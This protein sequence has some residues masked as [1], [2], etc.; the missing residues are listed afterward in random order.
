M[1]RGSFSYPGIINIST[2]LWNYGY[3]T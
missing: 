1:F 3:Y 2:F